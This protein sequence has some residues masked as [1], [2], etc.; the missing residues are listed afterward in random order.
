MFVSILDI[1]ENG[2]ITVVIIYVGICGYQCHRNI[3]FTCGIFFY[4]IFIVV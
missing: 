3:D 4:H 2:Y 1:V